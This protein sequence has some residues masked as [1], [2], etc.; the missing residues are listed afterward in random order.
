MTLTAWA[1]F[2]ATKDWYTRV[3]SRP[4]FRPLLLDRVAGFTPAGAY[5]DLDF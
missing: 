2:P 3:K 4:S 1:E 5:A